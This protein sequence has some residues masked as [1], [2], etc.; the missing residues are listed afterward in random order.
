MKNPTLQYYM[1]DGSTAFRFEL[2]GDL[3]S[4][5]VRELEQAWSTASSMIGDRR[6]IVDITFVT[7]VT[8]SGR[9]FISRWHEEGAQL[10][11]NSPASRRLAESILGQPLPENGADEAGR[12]QTWLPFRRSFL[13][14]LV[15]L[16]AVVVLVSPVEAD[17]ATLKPETVAAWDAYLV[18]VNENLQARLRPDGTFLWT[19]ENAERASD[20]RKGEIVVAPVTG[21]NPRKVPGGLIHHWIGAVFVPNLALDDVVEVTGDY[22]RY[23]DFYHPSVIESKAIA[24]D[25]ADAKFSMKIMNRAFFMK[26]ALDAEYQATNVRLED[27]RFLSVSKTTRVQEVEQCGEPGEHRIPEGEGGGYIWKLYSIARFEQRDGG[28]YVELEAIALSRDIPVAVRLVADPIVRRVSRDALHTSLRQT[29]EA[30]RGNVLAGARR[31]DTP[32]KAGQLSADPASRSI[33]SSAFRV[34]H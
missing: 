22:D 16:F 24:R 27:R 4:E 31:V 11:A 28:V 13:T 9:A 33:T 19:F 14:R 1:H 23:K 2:A 18:S 26:T 8:E 3:N 29:E 15:T 25:G 12:D 6:L 20:V 30:V 10:I 17:G 21:R 34:A 5:G 7:C 32:S